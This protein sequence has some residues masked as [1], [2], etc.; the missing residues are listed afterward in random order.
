MSATNQPFDL[1]D[2]ENIVIMLDRWSSPDILIQLDTISAGTCDIEGTTARI[3]QGETPV[4]AD[5][6][7]TTSSDP[8]G[9]AVFSGNFSEVGI[10]DPIPAPLE[11]IRISANG[12]DI[13]GRVM[14]A[15]HS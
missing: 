9:N 5:L 10:A 12:G 3:N 4:W 13:T 11:A 8:A 1:L 6:Y 15:D 7:G 14:Q 2:T